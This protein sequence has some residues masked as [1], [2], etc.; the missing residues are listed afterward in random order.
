M[1]LIKYCLIISV[2]VSFTAGGCGLYKKKGP[3]DNMSNEEIQQEQIRMRRQ[4][5]SLKKIQLGKDI[6]TLRNKL[7]S[8]TKEF[9]KIQKEMDKTNEEL[10]KKTNKK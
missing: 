6:D 1:K 9:N 3:F 8:Q 2:I 10:N 7:D 4:I 5:D